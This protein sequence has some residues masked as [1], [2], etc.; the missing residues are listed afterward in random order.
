MMEENHEMKTGV[1]EENHEMKIEKE[2]HVMKTEVKEENHEMKTEV[3]EE[4]HEMKIEEEEEENQ[5]MKIEEDESHEMKTEVKQEE[6]E[7]VKVEEHQDQEPD[8]HPVNTTNQTDPASSSGPPDLQGPKMAPVKRHAYDADFKLKAIRHAAEHGNR[9]AAREFSVNESMVRKWRKQEDDLRHAKKTTQSFR[10]NSARWP[11][12]EDQI[13]QWVTEQRAAGRSVSTVSIRRKATALA[14]DMNI[15]D[16][17]GGPSWCFRF[18]KRHNLTIRTQ[19]TVSQQLPEG[20][21]EKLATFSA[22]C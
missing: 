1:K 9:A 14:R 22:Y 13:E 5:K 17:L 16:F 6:N 10:G 4:N 19:T 11:Q 15:N 2:N 12:V 3:K 18:M 7:E 21:K 8:L 20:Y